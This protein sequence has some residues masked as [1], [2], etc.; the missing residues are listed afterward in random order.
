MV[1]GR[2]VARHI[3][4]SVHGVLNFMNRASMGHRLKLPCRAFANLSCLF[5][6]PGLEVLEKLRSF[7]LSSLDAMQ[8]KTLGPTKI[9]TPVLIFTDGA[10]EDGKA[11]WGAVILDE[12]TGTSVVHHGK[13]CCVLGGARAKN[14]SFVKL[15]LTPLFF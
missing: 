11:T 1:S 2:G 14:R 3:A 12:H 9:E 15:N 7:A 10:Y 8:P 4:R 13:V 5:E 6:D